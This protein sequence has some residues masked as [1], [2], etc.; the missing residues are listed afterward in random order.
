M[1]EHKIIVVI[2]LYVVLLCSSDENWSVFINWIRLPSKSINQKI[3][4]SLSLAGIKKY[5]R[6]VKKKREKKY[7]DLCIISQISILCV[8]T[9][10]T[11][12]IAHFTYD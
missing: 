4:E 3:F 12:Q 11:S 2:V 7:F 6:L 9:L 5:T 1:K 10:K 8:L